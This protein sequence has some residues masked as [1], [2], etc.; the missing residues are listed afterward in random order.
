MAPGPAWHGTEDGVETLNPARWSMEDHV[1]LT[2]RLGALRWS[3][4]T[5]AVGTLA[6]VAFGVDGTAVRTLL[7]AA[8]FGVV[9][10]LDLW[11]RHRLDLGVRP[12]SRLLV[13][14]VLVEGLAIVTALYLAGGSATPVRYAVVIHAA[15]TALLLSRQVA[16]R[17]AVWVSLLL[18]VSNEMQELGLIDAVDRVD[19][20]RLTTGPELGGLLIALWIATLLTASASAINERVLLRERLD[21]HVHASFGQAAAAA[22]TP[23]ET[24]RVLAEHVLRIGEVRQV[25]VVD[26]RDE[27]IVLARLGEDAERETVLTA[28]AGSL[29]HEVVAS[30]TTVRAQGLTDEADTDLRQLLG[31]P[32]NVFAV[33]M[34]AGD[35]AV[36]VLL[37]V[38]RDGV[39]AGL[40]RS[41][42]ESYKRLAAHA[43]LALANAWATERLDLQARTDALT[44]VA[45]RHT[46][47]EMFDK[48]L[49]RARRERSPLSLV[50]CDV[51]HFK[52]LN[53]Q[54]GHVVGDRTLAQIAQTLDRER[55]PYDLVA[56]YGGEEFVLIL[57]QA[58]FDE[59][60]RVAHRLR[61]AVEETGAELGVTASF[62]VATAEDGIA[63]RSDLVSTADACLYHAKERGRNRV[64]GAVT[65]LFDR[66]GVERL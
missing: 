55:R 17:S 14:T 60:M 45:N 10:L 22:G 13:G 2:E 59:A 40:Q 5:V 28:P 35:A 9:L 43:A 21:Q 51:D 34:V 65:Q 15:T 47:D 23:T 7:A 6:G 29:L 42:V 8:L 52:R 64:E 48:E 26:T 3:R 31:D 32:T 39:A 18:L 56:R 19:G 36:G 20:S 61:R 30:R 12:S 33:P 1:S 53:D 11:A 24:A 62:G 66:T 25:V 49:S 44:G 57:S 27:P 58:D 54:R 16:V 50:L 63:S 37:V 41:T 46:F 38:H 4:V